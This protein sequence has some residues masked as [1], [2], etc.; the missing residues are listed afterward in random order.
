MEKSMTRWNTTMNLAHSGGTIT[1]DRINIKRGIFQGDSLSPLLFCLALVPL[2]SQLNE[3]GY[4]YRMSKTSTPITIYFIWMI[5]NYMLK[6]M[7]N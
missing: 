3:T 5:L 7:N 2:S 1:T 6:T 4:G